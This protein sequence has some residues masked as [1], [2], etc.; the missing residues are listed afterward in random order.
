MGSRRSRADVLQR[1]GV[2]IFA[3][4]VLG[5]AAPPMG[6]GGAPGMGTQVRPGVSPIVAAGMP[7]QMVTIRAP[8]GG[9]TKQI[10]NDPAMIKHFTDLGATVVPSAGA[11]Q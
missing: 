11:M 6:W 10:P 5:G 3:G 9:A 8:K 7:G 4:I 1:I 2:A